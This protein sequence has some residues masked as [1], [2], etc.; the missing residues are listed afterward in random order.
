MSLTLTCV[1][2]LLSTVFSTVV[3]NY[4]SISIQLEIIENS[5]LFV[6]FVIPAG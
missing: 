1:P 6:T 2:L 4:N 5:H 3:T